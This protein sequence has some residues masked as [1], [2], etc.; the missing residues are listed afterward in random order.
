LYREDPFQAVILPM[1][2]GVGYALQMA[3]ATQ[4][5]HVVDVPCA[6]VVTD[7]SANRQIAN[8]EGMWIGHAVIRRQ[9][10]DISLALADLVLVFGPR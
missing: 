6:V 9:M 5:L 7:L 2:G 8:Q 4:A 10:E 1:W 3:R